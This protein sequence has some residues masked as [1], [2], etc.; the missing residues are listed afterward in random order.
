MLCTPTDGSEKE[1]SALK[2][3]CEFI[4]NR[5]QCQGTTLHQAVLDSDEDAVARYLKIPGEHQ[6]RFTYETEFKG[7]IQKGSGEAIHLAVSRGGLGVA[8]LLRPLTQA[9]LLY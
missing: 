7:K 2:A 3:E 9:R 1:R 6:K 4:W 5:R 8:N